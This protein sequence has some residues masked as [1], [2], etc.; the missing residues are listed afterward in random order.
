MEMIWGALA[1]GALS[2]L[3]L[4]LGMVSKETG[5]NETWPRP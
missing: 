4:L 5:V 1:M 3:G 2:L